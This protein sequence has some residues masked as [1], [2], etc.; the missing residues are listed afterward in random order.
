[1]SCGDCRV[2]DDAVE[3]R[4]PS[5]SISAEDFYLREGDGSLV[6]VGAMGPPAE[7]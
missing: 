1:M 6:K 3:A 2:V 4:T 7:E 5:R